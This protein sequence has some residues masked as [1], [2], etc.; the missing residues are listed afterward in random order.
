MSLGRLRRCGG[1]RTV[2]AGEDAA[3]AAGHRCE[4]SGQALTG[5]GYMPALVR[6]QCVEE[7]FPGGRRM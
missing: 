5:V 2:T 7:A 1:R 3:S 6:G 4:C